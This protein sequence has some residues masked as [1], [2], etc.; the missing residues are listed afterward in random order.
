MKLTSKRILV[1]RYRFIGDTV[2]TVPFLRNLRRAEPD[3][4]IAWMVAPGSSDVVK[5]IPYV[6]DMIYWDPVTIHADSRGTHRT[7]SAK[8][9]FIKELRL[10]HFDKV[11]V[12]KRSL[13]SAIIAWLSGARERIGFDTEGRGF[14][15][16]KKVPYR[17]DRHEVENFLDVLRTDGVKVEDDF[18]EIW[19]T[20][21]EED[22]TTRLLS[23][24][25]VAVSEQRVMIHPF[26]AVA[27]RGWPL[28]NFAELAIRLSNEA[29][30]R[31]I[32]VGGAGDITTFKKVKPSFGERTVDLVGKC[33]LRETIALLKRCAL[34]VGNDSGIMHLAAAAGT[35]LVALFGPQSPVKFGPWSRRAKVIYKV[36]NCSPCRQKFFSECEPSARMRPACMEAIS[37]EEVFQES[38]TIAGLSARV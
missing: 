31:P 28:E 15:L 3:A 38:V 18:L 8:M 36:M 33:S 7:F 6:D 16:T 19:T 34:F 9:A 23:D 30:C 12:L 5:G 17:H 22:H 20:A 14:L 27:E 35:P 10:H 32:V 4:Y 11:Y 1:M 37:V 2:L 21:Q 24:A 26:S 25:G 13:S 29:N